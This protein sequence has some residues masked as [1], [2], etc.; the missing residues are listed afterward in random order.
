MVRTRSM[1]FPAAASG[2]WAFL[3]ISPRSVLWALLLVVIFFLMSL[4]ALSAQSLVSVHGVG[5]PVEDAIRQ[6]ARQ[7]ETSIQIAPGVPDQ[8]IDLALTDVPLESALRII[9][10]VSGLGWERLEDGYRV[11]ALD[12]KGDLSIPQL[13]QQTP[14]ARQSL[15]QS[16]GW[17]T[18]SL[19]P[20]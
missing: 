12:E 16:P 7:S 2:F 17:C 3:K 8:K 4:K 15:L 18:R 6:I 1:F 13:T 20:K 14:P 5:I 19:N 10:S 11:A 9:S